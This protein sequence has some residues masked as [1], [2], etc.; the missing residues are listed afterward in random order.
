[1]LTMLQIIDDINIKFGSS[2]TTNEMPKWMWEIHNKFILKGYI[3][4]KKNFKKFWRCPT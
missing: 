2:F 3:F 1:M 4:L